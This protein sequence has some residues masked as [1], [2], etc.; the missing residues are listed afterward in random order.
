MLFRSGMAGFTGS[1]PVSGSSTQSPITIKP[2]ISN[3][4]KRNVSVMIPDSTVFMY[5]RKPIGGSISSISYNFS[6]ASPRNISALRTFPGGGGTLIT[7]AFDRERK[8]IATPQSPFFF[9]SSGWMTLEMKAGRQVV[10]GFSQPID[11]IMPIEDSL[12]NP[13]TKTRF[14]LGDTIRIWSLDEKAMWNEESIAIV[15]NSSEGLI[16]KMKITHLSTWNF[17]SKINPCTLTI[18]YK[19]LGSQFWA[20][21]RF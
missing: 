15:E 13:E 11:L 7:D 2:K 9:A 17:D 21:T 18:S 8:K 20:Y 14:R 19:N 16:A 6:Y 10:N 3:Q 1:F 4:L 12:I 5:N